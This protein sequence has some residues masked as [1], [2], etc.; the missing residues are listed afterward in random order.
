MIGFD[1]DS[2]R[3]SED[4][5]TVTLTVRLANG[6]LQTNVSAQFS[7]SPDS[8]VGK[9]LQNKSLAMK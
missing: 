6:V 7:T 9:L 4:A 8:A 2:Y 3:V 5:G 1:P